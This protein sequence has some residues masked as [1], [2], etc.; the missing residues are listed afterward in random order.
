MIL[1]VDFMILWLW[2][3]KVTGIGVQRPWQRPDVQRMAGKKSEW[4]ECRLTVAQSQLF[5]I[6]GLIFAF[7]SPGLGSYL[8]SVS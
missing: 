4:D 1:E 3:L 7:E 2:S 5:L 6:T 8:S